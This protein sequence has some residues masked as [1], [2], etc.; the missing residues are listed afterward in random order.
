MEQ[1]TKIVSVAALPQVRVLGRTTGTDVVNLF[2]TGSGIK[3]IKS[4][5]KRSKHICKNC[6]RRNL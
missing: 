3:P 6:Y 2:W 1:P 5:R 4:P